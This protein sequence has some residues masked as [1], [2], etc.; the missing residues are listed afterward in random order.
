MDA[1][2]RTSDFELALPSD[3][4]I[5]ITRSFAAPRELVWTAMTDAAHV[6]RWWGCDDFATTVCEI[7]LRIGGRFRFEM[8]GPDGVCHPIIGVYREIVRP[9]RLVHT[10]IYDVPA[11][12]DREALVTVTLTET[13]GRRTAYA[14][15]IA[16]A[17]RADRDAHIASGMEGGASAALDRIEH[18]LLSPS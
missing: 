7:D 9:E 10:Q 15:L 12:A 4:E 11:Y 8:R 17:T 13:H 6:R 14:C 2:A 1:R 16:H 3:R 5:L 18:L